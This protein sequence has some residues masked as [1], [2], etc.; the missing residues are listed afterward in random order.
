MLHFFSK[1]LV[2]NM[3][4]I[5]Y[6]NGLSHRSEYS[7]TRSV[8]CTL[9]CGRMKKV[10]QAP[11]SQHNSKTKLT[12][13]C[14]LSQKLGFESTTMSEFWVITSAYQRFLL[15]VNVRLLVLLVLYFTLHQI[16]FKTCKVLPSTEISNLRIKETT[17]PSLSITL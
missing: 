13:R 7:F 16:T 2:N 17:K 9:S 4:S 1:Q 3:I 14:L 10:D 8:V 6:L 5:S 12:W 11:S 15:V